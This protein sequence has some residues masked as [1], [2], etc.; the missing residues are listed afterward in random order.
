VTPP[1]PID[2]LLEIIHTPLHRILVLSPGPP[3]DPP[4]KPPDKNLSF[5]I[6]IVTLR[7]RSI[8]RREVVIGIS[9]ILVCYAGVIIEIFIFLI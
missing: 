6:G 2:E 5:V 3:L 8:S 9:F 4:P 7:T 1:K